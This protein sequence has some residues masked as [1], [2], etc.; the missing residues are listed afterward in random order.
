MEFCSATKTT[1]LRI[2]L[3]KVDCQPHHHLRFLNKSC[4][5]KA[6]R[7]KRASSAATLQ[8]TNGVLESLQLSELLMVSALLHAC[9]DHLSLMSLGIS[10]LT[11]LA[12]PAGRRWDSE[13]HNNLGLHLCGRPI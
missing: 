7:A 1:C 3:R 10:L 2:S 11:H 13:L 6:S 5:R 9:H 4:Y 8:F 12:I